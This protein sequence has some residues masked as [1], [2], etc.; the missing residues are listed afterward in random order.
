MQNQEQPQKEGQG[1]G[2]RLGRVWADPQ[3]RMA[4]L[5]LLTLGA[6]T[7][8][9]S[10]ALASSSSYLLLPYWGLMTWLVQEPV[11]GW[12]TPIWRV[13]KQNS[14]SATPASSFVST[15]QA[16]Q[17]GRKPT[18]T[19]RA[20]NQAL[21]AAAAGIEST[22]Q[23]SGPG[24]SPTNSSGSETGGEPGTTSVATDSASLGTRKRGRGKSRG[25]QAEEPKPEPEPVRWVKVGPGKFVRLDETT[26]GAAAT[27]IAHETTAEPP[28]TSAI[29][30][31]ETTPKSTDHDPAS[32]SE[33]EGL[34]V[35]Q[36]TPVLAAGS[37]AAPE[38]EEDELEG[39]A[40][41]FEQEPSGAKQEPL[42]AQALVDP[43]LVENAHADD[44]IRQGN[45]LPQVETIATE[46]NSVALGSKFD[47]EPTSALNLPADDDRRIWFRGRMTRQGLSLLTPP[48]SD[49]EQA[50][51]ETANPERG[52]P[53]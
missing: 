3:A 42:G 20:Q 15:N 52:P 4:A 50:D 12:L 32:H 25:R 35:P 5:Q 48:S 19:K 1:G 28:S 51:A 13:W 17:V 10:S 18:R 8:A 39:N 30:I 6:V 26:A 46:D 24:E 7:G 45:G 22:S 44:P 33:N 2:S 53:T 23:A 31:P 43:L 40:A 49:G 29:T 9:A 21:V 37:D 47:G 16:E 41:P 11:R 38:T 34:E 27:E 36:T 14:T